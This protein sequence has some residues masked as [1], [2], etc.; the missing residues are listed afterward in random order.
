MF[1]IV[2]YTGKNDFQTD[3]FF[4]RICFENKVQVPS[5]YSIRF[6]SYTWSFLITCNSQNVKKKL[7]HYKKLW[8]LYLAYNSTAD[9]QI[10][11]DYLKSLTTA[12]LILFK[13][14]NLKKNPDHAL[15]MKCQVYFFLAFT[16]KDCKFNYTCVLT[17]S[18]SCNQ[19]WTHSN[20]S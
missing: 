9:T 11:V 19:W 18:E 4:P 12:L 5:V 2:K 16:F 1:T 8:N 14:E 3:S 6:R 13:N 17:I 20:F 15:L 10:L 7:F